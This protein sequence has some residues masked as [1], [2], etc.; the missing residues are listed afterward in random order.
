[1]CLW[2][3]SSRSALGGLLNVSV[4]LRWVAGVGLVLVVLE[5]AEVVVAGVT[6]TT[7]AAGKALVEVAVV[8]AVVGVAWVSVQPAA[9]AVVFGVV[10]VEV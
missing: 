7:G 9:A 3:L 2:R 4:E 6:C 5:S 1:M 8:V 10:V